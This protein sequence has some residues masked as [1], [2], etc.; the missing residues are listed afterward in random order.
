MLGRSGMQNASPHS[1]VYIQYALLRTRR[2][3]CTMYIQAKGHAYNEM[4]KTWNLNCLFCCGGGRL[5]RFSIF[6]S[7]A[8]GRIPQ[9]CCLIAS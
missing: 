1:T 5:L 3:E 8:P 2:D 7:N 9:D 6:V 4:E